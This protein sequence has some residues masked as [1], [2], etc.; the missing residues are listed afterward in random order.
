MERRGVIQDSVVI[1]ISNIRMAEVVYG[2]HVYKLEG[3]VIPLVL[4]PS[5]WVELGTVFFPS[6]PRE[7]D[8][9]RPPSCGGPWEPTFLLLTHRGRM[10][11]IHV[12]PHCDN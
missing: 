1:K 7:E 12:K 10:F 11:L 8:I 6:P 2:M 9:Q 3:T 4:K 5:K